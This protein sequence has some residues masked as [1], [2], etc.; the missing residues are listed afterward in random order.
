MKIY[1]R[2]EEARE[3]LTENAPLRG[4]VVTIGNFDGV[5]LGHQALIR[6]AKSLAAEL[7]TQAGAITFWPHP[8]RILAPN[9]APPLI[10]SR[11]RRRELLAETGLDFL[12]EHPFTSD[13]AS[14]PA[15]RFTRTLLDE[16]GVGGIVVGYDFT[17]G[18]GRTGNVETLRAACAE[19]GAR[20]EVVQPVAVDGLVVSSSKVREFVLAGNVKE[21]RTLLGRPFEV[22]GTVVRG[23]GR[24]RTIGVP[25][26]NVAGDTELVPGMG[27]YATLV[28]LPDGSVRGGACNVGL[29]PTF[30]PESTDGLSSRAVSIEVN[31]LDF[32]GDLYGQHLR[33]GFVQCLRPERRFPG[34]EA[35][36]AQ[37]RLDIEETRQVLAPEFATR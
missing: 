26:A 5:H 1:E 7:G 31:I 14:L 3:A 10:S 37:I 18:K 17:Y 8:V 9:R 11:A 22:E 24:G 25:T 30:K 33:L 28:R 2:L 16:L 4:A 20:L 27:V 32:D 23:A 13:F 35:L 36:V 15:E 21:A 12:V 19:R 6:G 29:N 34:V